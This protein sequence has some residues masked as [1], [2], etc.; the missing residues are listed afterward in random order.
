[1]FGTPRGELATITHSFTTRI[2]SFSYSY[3]IV[4]LPVTCRFSDTQIRHSNPLFYRRYAVSDKVNRGRYIEN[5]SFYLFL[6][7]YF[8]FLNIFYS[9]VV[10]LPPSVAY[11]LTREGGNI[12][13]FKKRRLLRFCL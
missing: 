13:I 12:H 7:L 2:S 10:F 6:R 5:N 8:L 3:L 9:F 4:F 1:M 11:M